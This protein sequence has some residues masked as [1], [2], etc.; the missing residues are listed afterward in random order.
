M[1]NTHV[2]HDC[3]IGNN[4]ILANNAV[5]G[6]HVTIGDYAILGVTRRFSNSPGS[7]VTP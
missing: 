3:T 2:A 1:V 5:M 6:G 4:V 7:V